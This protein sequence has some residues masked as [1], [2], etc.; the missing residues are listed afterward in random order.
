M[1][2]WKRL[3]AIAAVVA[4]GLTG[5]AAGGSDSSSGTPTT[6]TLGVLVPATTFEASGLNWANESPYG[7][8]V[9]DSLLR[10][11]PDGSIAPNL[12]TDYTYNADKTVLTLKL[13]TDVKFT[14]GTALDAS[15]VAQNLLRFR[16]GTSPNK[17]YLAAVADA[18]ATDTSTVTITLKA[19]DPS[20][21]SNLTRNAGMVESPAAFTKADVATNPVG[22]GPYILDVAKTVVGTS[23]VFEKNPNYWKPA[24]VHYDNLTL[25]VFSDA[26][27]LL[28]AI[29]G[30]QVNATN[31]ASNN[32]LDQITAA[33][34]T[35]NPLE[36]N[37]TGLMLI[38]RDGTSNPALGDVRVRQ[39][40]NYAFDTK[41]LLQAVGQGYGTPTSQIF[42]KTSV[43][44]DPALDSAYTYDP[45]KAK[46]LL[47]AAGY[48]N[49]LT[50]QMP[51]T[52]LLGTAVFTLYAQQLKDVGITVN[53]TDA[54]NNY[55]SDVLAPKY[56]SYYFIL[57]EDPDWALIQFSIAP[58]ATFN[59]YHTQNATVDAL[60]E[61]IHNGSQADSDQAVKD[62]NKYVVD[63]AWFAPWYR[64]QSSFA[65]DAHT[66][67]T[68]QADNAYPYLW[69]F[70]PIS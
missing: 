49:G 41:A 6:L 18:T 17:S 23:Y 7:Q 69:N 47:A 31:T 65:T 38:D 37:W 22:S 9:Y 33:G 45:A 70:T 63:N 43:G 3:T 28:N 19:S 12:A 2:R 59:S 50:L 13:R 34:F 27:A 32:D 44:Y 14:D 67:V 56:G 10:G 57:Q 48:A 62:L 66:K 58:T 39:A 30:G 25:S 29:K 40:I 54:G 52:S 24:D 16:D 5:C 1:F 53:F 42:P 11:N 64:M 68:V 51:S 60:I 8:A 61:K 20:L 15:A 26:T 36:L 55:I 35:I 46:A 21:L 4:L